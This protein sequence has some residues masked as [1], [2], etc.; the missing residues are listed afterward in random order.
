MLKLHMINKTKEVQK[1][2]N[3]CCSTKS[4]YHCGN[5]SSAIYGLGIFGA[6]FYFLQGAVTFT[7]VIVGIFKSVFWPA[8][9]LFKVLTLLNL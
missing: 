3:I 7:A 4:K 8:F 6:L 5:N 1:E 2:K 9:L